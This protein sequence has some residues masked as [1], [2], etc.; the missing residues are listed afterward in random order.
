ML[1]R[2]IGFPGETEED[3]AHTVSL[4]REVEYDHAYIFK[5]S[6][7]PGTDAAAREDDV[8]QDVKERRN[9][10]LLQL[11]DTIAAERHARF[12]GTVQ[13]ILIEGPAKQPGQLF[14]RTRG[15]HG[16]V[17]DGPPELIGRTVSVS[18]TRAT[19]HTIFGVLHD[20]QPDCVS[21]A[22]GCR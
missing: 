18:V 16:V 8:P 5:Y 3:F 11:Q 12:I 19:P 15:N 14:G 17:L 10:L 6:P 20:H 1:F 4:L 22:D 21:R 7:R 9:H 2:S 13:E